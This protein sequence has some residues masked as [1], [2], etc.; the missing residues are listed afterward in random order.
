MPGVRPGIKEFHLTYVAEAG[1]KV[2]EKKEPEKIETKQ[3]KE[4]AEPATG[5]PIEMRKVKE[6]EDDLDSEFERY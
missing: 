2:A 3:P 1:P 6:G 5:Y 4:S